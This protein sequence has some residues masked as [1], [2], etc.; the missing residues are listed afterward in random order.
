V[1]KQTPALTKA[2]KGWKPP[3]DAPVHELAGA[4]SLATTDDGAA[5]ADEDEIE[6]NEVMSG[7]SFASIGT[8]VPPASEL[9]RII[10]AYGGAWIGGGIGD[11][12][13]ITHL[14]ASEAEV[15]KTKR[16][17]KY[18]AAL[19][20]G[21]PIVSATYILAL[22]SIV[23]ENEATP[24]PAAA[25]T[26]RP[27]PATIDVH[28]C[29]EEEE[30]LA[31]FKVAELK[32]RLVERGL[33]MGGKKADLVKRLR[34]ARPATMDKAEATEDKPP[35][36]T[37]PDGVKRKRKLPD[38]A[39]PSVP[40]VVGAKLRQRKHMAAYV[41]AGGLG[42][43]LPSV[44]SARSE[45]QVRKAAADARAPKPRVTLPPITP[46]SAILTVDPDAE[47]TAGA[48]IYVDMHNLVY[49]TTLNQMD[50][51]SGVNK[52]YRMQL[53]TTGKNRDRYSVFKAWGRVGGE[54][55]GGERFYGAHTNSNLTHA[56]EGN[57]QSAMSEFHEKFLELACVPFTEAV[58]P[59]QHTGG[60][61]VSLIPGQLGKD[62]ASEHRAAVEQTGKAATL[63]TAKMAPPSRLAAPVR[64]FVELIFSEQMMRQQMEALSIDLEQ[65]PLGTISDVQVE[66]GY[67][68]LRQIADV[69]KDPLAD[70]G[71]QDQ[72]LL[73][74]TAQFYNTI[75]HKFDRRH[76]PPVITT[77][78][79]LVEKIE[80][81]EALLQVSKAQSLAHEMVGG[82]I[83]LQAHP[84]DE[85]YAKLGCGLEPASAEEMALVQEYVANTH[86]K[87][88]NQFTLKVRS[89]LRAERSG[90]LSAHASSLGNRKL[91]W[92]GSRLT[93]WVGI[94]SQGLRIAPPEAPVSGYV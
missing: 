18:Q 83:Q 92:H 15:R 26:K 14:I 7:L 38:L 22:A 58:P 71:A 39:A 50:I 37:H 70:K 28:V 93:N 6:E 57:L 51:R 73:A 88:H 76:T 3:A 11:G 74:L 17:V 29:E 67:A 89:V 34:E 62:I 69:L 33:D 78:Q 24:A 54:E 25:G 9:Q 12:S 90:E 79:M 81:I 49:N 56:H 59:C 85:S 94:L 2:L 82:S 77:Q 40:K 63:A 52:Y 46:G 10:E 1:Y 65:M 53:L 87:T 8:T 45:Q 13:I 36:Q 41:L 27:R 31:S 19:N 84:A 86:A 61:N 42:P 32:V 16:S 4:A 21:V 44:A 48:S 91:L 75:P 43:R 35:L 47:I 80:A 66:R 72:L 55:G 20:G 5:S 68:T 64:E 23:D 30:D 60:Y